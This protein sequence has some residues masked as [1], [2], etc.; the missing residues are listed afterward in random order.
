[1]SGRFEWDDKKAAANW[2]DHGITFDQAVK[3]AHKRKCVVVLGWA[4]EGKV[5]LLAAVSEELTKKGL[6]AGKL[7]GEAAKVVEGKGGGNPTLAQAGGKDPA[8][9]SDALAVAKRLA[10]EKLR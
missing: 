10:T 5:S 7:V 8:K 2:R 3:A 4:D 9:L 1:M 6:H